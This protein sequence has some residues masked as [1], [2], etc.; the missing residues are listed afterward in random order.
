MKKDYKRLLYFRKIAQ[1][2]ITKAS[3]KLPIGQNKKSYKIYF[4]NQK[5]T[6]AM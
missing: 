6:N 3:T 5:N 2:N 4:I 1:L